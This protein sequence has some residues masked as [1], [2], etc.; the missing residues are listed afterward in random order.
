MPGISLADLFIR[1]SIEYSEHC[2]FRCDRFARPGWRSE[3]HVRVGMVQRVKY[4]RLDGV[5][6]S[7]REQLL[8]LVVFQCRHGQW[9]QVEKV[10]VRSS[11]IRSTSG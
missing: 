5:E 1:L 2:E 4:L 8:V 11:L 10:W 9:S 6:M 3:Q 7:V